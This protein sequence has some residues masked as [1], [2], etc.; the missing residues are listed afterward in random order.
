MYVNGVFTK[1]KGQVIDKDGVFYFPISEFTDVYNIDVEY[2][3]EEKRLNIDKLSEEKSVAFV[4]RDV[5]L[6][7]KM[8][9]ISK[10]IEKLEQGDIVTVIQDNNDSEWVKVK[11]EDY[12]VGYVKKNKLT[13]ISIERSSL[14]LNSEEFNNFDFDNDVVVEITDETYKDFNERIIDY[15][16]RTKL[17]LE[18]NDKIKKEITKASNSDKHI[19][20]KMNITNVQNTENYYHFLRELKAYVNSNGCF[21]IV[22]RQTNLDNNILK[23]IANILV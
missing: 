19:G 18:L 7:Y 6:K 21:L 12:V 9:D 5:N 8:T 17:S 22:A 4:N 11:T 20:I 23:N 3:K 14:G 16:S 10:T 15:D 13:D 2:L 1:I